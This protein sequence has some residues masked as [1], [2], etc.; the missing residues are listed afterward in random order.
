MRR[1]SAKSVRRV[2][3]R[4]MYRVKSSSCQRR[5][6]EDWAREAGRYTASRVV[7]AAA[8]WSSNQCARVARR[9]AEASRSRESRRGATMDAAEVWTGKGRF[10][11]NLI[12][13]S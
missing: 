13:T 4:A 8:G 3:A 6:A 11:G 7:K 10:G 5:W 1:R 12:V 2:R 9:C